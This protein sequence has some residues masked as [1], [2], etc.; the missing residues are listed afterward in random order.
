V[1]YSVIQSSQHWL[2]VIIVRI[3]VG[4]VNCEILTGEVNVNFVN[5]TE[6]LTCFRDNNQRTVK[7]VHNLLVITFTCYY[8]DFKTT[9]FKSSNTL[10]ERFIQQF[11]V[12]VWQEIVHWEMT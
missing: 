2:R 11:P 1:I 12:T 10:P 9:T 6:R 5:S 3:T 7:Q 4:H 8:Q